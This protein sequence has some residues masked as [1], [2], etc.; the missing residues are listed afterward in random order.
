MPVFFVGAAM[1]TMRLS[2]AFS[3]AVCAWFRAREP[4][5]SSKQHAFHVNG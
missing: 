5:E 4:W 2:A 1:A 3:A